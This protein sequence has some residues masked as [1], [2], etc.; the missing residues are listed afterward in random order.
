MPVYSSNKPPVVIFGDSITSFGV[1]RGLR[2]LRVPIYIVSDNGKGIGT[3]SRYVKDVLVLPPSDPNYVSNVLDWITRRIAGKPVLLVAGN[4]D[5]LELLSKQHERVKHYT[6]PTFPAW[7]VV[8]TAINKEQAYALARKIGIATIA[9]RRVDSLDELQAYLQSADDIQ[10]PVFLKCAY[11]RRFSQA[12]GTKGV[13]CRSPGEVMEVYEEYNGF[14]GALLVQEFIPGD[15]DNIFAVLLV[16]NKQGK[17]IAV[18]ANEKIRSSSL[19][20]STTLSS[21]MW[22]QQL[23]E[24]AVRLAESVGYVGFVGVQFK[25]DPRDDEYKFLEINGRFSVSVSLAQRCGINMPEMVYREFSGES[26]LRL[27]AL[28]QNYPSGILLWWP[29][30]D[31]VLLSQIRFYRE[32]IRYLASLMG[33]GYIIE[34]I[35][36]RDPLPA[37]ITLRGLLAGTLR[38]IAKV[39]QSRLIGRLRSK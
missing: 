36:W 25:Y 8:A 35:S 31:V 20:G 28:R 5:A 19:Y 16:L 18:A 22:N 34:P 27:P 17:V 24:R 14:L 2:K 1:I 39:F 26:F 7:E 9:T 32:P 29:L 12:Y 4:D 13:I 30:S 23:V 6:V 3:Y 21:S 11:S 38:K 37:L 33:T 10:F 15:I